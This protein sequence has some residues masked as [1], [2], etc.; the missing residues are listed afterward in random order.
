[1]ARTGSCAFKSHQDWQD[2][3]AAREGRAPSRE[4]LTSDRKQQDESF[5]HLQTTFVAAVKSI[6]TSTR[7]TCEKHL[8]SGSRREVPLFRWLLHHLPL[9]KRTGDHLGDAT[10]QKHSFVAPRVASSLESCQDQATA[11]CLRNQWQLHTLRL[12]N[13]CCRKSRYTVCRGPLV[14]WWTQSFA[15]EESSKVKPLVTFSV[16]R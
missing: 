2:W 5:E 9:L 10:L 12:V 15:V 8:S 4:H 6:V 7:R 14:H 13:R 11:C 3:H 1:M 16:R